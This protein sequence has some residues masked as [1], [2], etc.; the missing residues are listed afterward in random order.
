MS[1]IISSNPLAEPNTPNLDDEAITKILSRWP[2]MELL[3]ERSGKQDQLVA[4]LQAYIGDLR[5]EAATIKVLRVVTMAAVG[6]YIIFVNLL[7]VCLLFYHQLFFLTLGT[8]GKPVLI[9]AVFS[10]SVIL[11][12]KILVGLFRTHGD[13]NKD[14][15]LP[16][17]MSAAM[18]L[19]NAT[20]N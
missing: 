15:M 4:D 13:R 5:S 20:Q 7:L 14:E 19:Y 16:P 11:L 2:D 8:Y 6:I 10:S 17:H 12:A 18:E 1:D 3:L 9:L